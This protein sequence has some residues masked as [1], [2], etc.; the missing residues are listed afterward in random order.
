MQ[1]P[2]IKK[3]PVVKKKAAK[4]KVA[5]K[6]PVTK[7]KVAKKKP[8]KKKDVKKRVRGEYTW[9]ELNNILAKTTDEKKLLALIAEEKKG[10]SRK[11]WVMRIFQRYSIVRARRERAEITKDCKQ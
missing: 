2:V 5:K 10:H 3:K 11:I 8:A 4:K 6:K 1:R 7:K 9:L